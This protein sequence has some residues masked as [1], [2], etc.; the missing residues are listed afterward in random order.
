MIV[1]IYSKSRERKVSSILVQLGREGYLLATTDC[2]AICWKELSYFRHVRHCFFFPTNNQLFSV[3]KTRAQQIC[4]MLCYFT[5]YSCSIS[6]DAQSL[7]LKLCCRQP[8]ISEHDNFRR[9]TAKRNRRRR[10][11]N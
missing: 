6:F 11:T 9:R 2:F 7:Y 3:T 8:E 4:R 5:V 1:I 10:N